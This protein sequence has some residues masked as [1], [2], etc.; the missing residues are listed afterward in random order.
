[1]KD[2]KEKRHDKSTMSLIDNLVDSNMNGLISDLQ[3]LVKVPSV[4]AK[5]KVWLN[6]LT[7]LQIL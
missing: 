7:F 1:M 4:S 2:K 5:N 3:T 6:V